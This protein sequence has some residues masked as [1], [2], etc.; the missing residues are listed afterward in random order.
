MIFEKPRNFGPGYLN[1]CRSSELDF[2]ES[3]VARY[4]RC[5]RLPAGAAPYLLTS[6]FTYLLT[7]WSRVI[8]EKLTGFQLV[9]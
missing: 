8:L 3:Y 2:V 6:L 9:K 5:G 1:L 7:P 4:G